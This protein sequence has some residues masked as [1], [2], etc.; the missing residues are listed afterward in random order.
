MFDNE[1]A[2]DLNRAGTPLLEIVSE[3]ELSSA[4]EASLY[5]QKMH[6]WFV[7]SNI[8]WQYARRII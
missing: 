1:T 3:P 7:I 4:K 6:Q 5:M 2:I 8:R